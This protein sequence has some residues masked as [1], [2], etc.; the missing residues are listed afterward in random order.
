MDGL[1]RTAYSDADR[2]HM[3]RALELAERGLFTTTP[4]PRVGCVIT[5]D[6]NP[7]GEGWHV[8]A[9]EAHAEVAALTD[10][11]AREQEVRGATLYVT[12]SPCNVQGRTPPCVDEIIRAGITR[13][14]AAMRDPG[15]AQADGLARLAA[16]GITVDV[17]LLEAEARELNRGFVSRIARG[18]P[19]VRSKIAATLDG[20]T[21]LASGESRWITGAPARDDGHAWRARACAI[22]TGVG[23]VLHDDPQLNVRAVATSRQPLK[24]I[25]DRN[26]DV[27][28]GA[29]VLEGGPA[30]IVTAGPRNPAW[31]DDVDVL[32]LP[33]GDERVDLGA[34]MRELARRGVNEVH[35]ECGAKLNG[36][37]LRAGL[38][39]ELLVYLAGGLIG[40]PARGMFEFPEP[41][42]ALAGRTRL[43][44]KAIDRIGEDL[45]IIARIEG[46]E[47]G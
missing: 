24:V 37:L 3:A 14:V 9:G 23:T 31:P 21:A 41:L 20:R 13:V 18:L 19:W 44:W 4:N 27:P 12:L 47:E 10:A 39:D 26:G 38:I 36:A 42:R 45:R 5:R 43:R 35:V 29:R 16:A 1:S 8:R 17:G 32:A 22:L 2:A 34:M 30:M 28:A 11:N 25:V 7:I 40:D 46:G 33:D 6:G 15:A